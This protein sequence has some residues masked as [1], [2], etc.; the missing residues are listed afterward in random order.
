[1]PSKLTTEEFIRR[2][3]KSH[4]YKYD[5][6]KSIYTSAHGKVEVIC[7]KHG[8]FW[9]G[10]TSHF[11]GHG[12]PACSNLKR[13]TT[14]EFVQR[15]KKVHGD[16]YDYS[17]SVYKRAHSN[18]KVICKRHGE[19]SITPDNHVNGAKGCYLCT[20]VMCFDKESFIR[21][22][23]KSHGDFYDYSQVKYKNTTVPVS[24][25][26]PL[27]GVFNQSPDNHKKGH[28]C[29]KCAAASRTSSL[30]STTSRFIKIASVTHNGF[31]DYSLV[32]YVKNTVKVEIICPLHGVFYQRPSNHLN[33][34]GCPVCGRSN[35][36]GY[37]FSDWYSHGVKSKKFKGWSFYLVNLFNSNESF[38]KYGITY[39]RI[40]ERMASIPYQYEVVYLERIDNLLVSS[41]REIWDLENRFSKSVIDKTYNPLVSFNGYTECFKIDG[42]I[43][44]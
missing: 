44:F 7:P 37:S 20:G 33:G 8:S 9:Q 41:A 24:I 21:E 25:I 34:S 22:S 4:G 38:S 2:S 23:K 19:F 13:P 14:K 6:S 16:K 26:C 28:G 12:C 15:A 17:L 5:Y 40:S 18:V 29:P 31:Y 43:A 36:M 42:I 30:R 39:T 10:A 27:H 3:I 35:K 32:D 1:M 11:K